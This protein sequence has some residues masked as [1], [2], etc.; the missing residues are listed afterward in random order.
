MHKITDDSTF[1][2]VWKQFLKTPAHC[3]SVARHTSRLRVVKW[4]RCWGLERPQWD[5]ENDGLAGVAGT[6]KGRDE[7]GRG[8]SFHYTWPDPAPG[9]VQPHLKWKKGALCQLIYI[10][11]WNKDSPQNA[12]R[13]LRER[14]REKNTDETKEKCGFQTLKRRLRR[15]TSPGKMGAESF[16]VRRHKSAFWSVHLSI[17]DSLRDWIN[18]CPPEFQDKP[19]K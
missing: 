1:W 10:Y 18:N 16:K 7:R 9:P 17:P 2:D 19:L 14:E 12:S 15:I 3:C 8:F 4:D 5:I 6:I 13:D 11:I